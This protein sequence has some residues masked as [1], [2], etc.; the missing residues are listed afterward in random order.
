LFT[1]TRS[2]E[3]CTALPVVVPRHTVGVPATAAGQ[4][5]TSGPLV[6]WITTIA[7]APA[8]RLFSVIVH[9]WLPITTPV[10][11]PDTPLPG[12]PLT[13]PIGAVQLWPTALAQLGPRGPGGKP[14]RIW[15]TLLPVDV[16]DGVAVASISRICWTSCCS[17]WTS[18]WS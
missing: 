8:G 7:C 14:F 13:L 10:A 1:Y 16:G 3:P 9:S 11:V 5:I 17:C 15:L 4:R 2:D 6:V 12:L 18:C